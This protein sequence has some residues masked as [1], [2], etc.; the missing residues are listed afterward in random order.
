MRTWAFGF[1]PAH[2]AANGHPLHG[3][4]QRVLDFQGKTALFEAEIGGGDPQP[5]QL[6]ITAALLD[7]ELQFQRNVGR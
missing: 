1:E 3:F 4:A 5:A 7:K 6:H 2:V